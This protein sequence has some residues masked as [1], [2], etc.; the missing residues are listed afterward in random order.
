MNRNTF[1]K[2]LCT[3]SFAGTKLA[4]L[5][6]RDNKPQV[7][8]RDF[9]NLFKNPPAQARPFFRWWWNGNSVTKEG[10]I[11]EINLMHEAGIGGIEINPIAFPKDVDATNHHSLEWLSAEWTDMLKF[12]VEFA[13]KKGMIVDLIIGSGWPFGGKFLES[14]EK[15]QIIRLNEVELK[16]PLRY[17]TT[18]EAL[19][20]PE[21]LRETDAPQKIIFLRLLPNSTDEYHAGTDLLDRIQSDGTIEFD[22]PAGEYLLVAGVWQEGHVQVQHGA[23]GSDGPVLNHYNKA[24]VRKYFDNMA[25]AIEPVMGKLGNSF[26]SFFIDSLELHGA[27]W[28]AD[29]AEEFSNRRGYDIDPYMPVIFDQVNAKGAPVSNKVDIQDKS[30]N[31]DTLQRVRYDYYLT[32]VEL[33]HERFGMVFHNFCQGKNLQSRIQAYGRGWHILDAST[34]PDI[35]EGETW[36]FRTNRTSPDCALSGRNNINLHPPIAN[37]YVTS[38]AQLSNKKIVSCETA[39]NGNAIFRVTPEHLKRIDDLNFLQNLNH[40][41]WSGFNYSPPEA[42]FPGWLQ[43]GPF[44]NEQNPWWKYM[45]HFSDYN[46]RLSSV[47]QNSQPQNDILILPPIVDSWIESGLLR[48]PFPD[49]MKTP[50]Y[51]HQLWIT[52]QQNGY[53]ANYTSENMIQKAEYK[54]GRMHIAGRSYRSLI[55]CSIRTVSPRAAKKIRQLADLGMRIL[56]IGT[57]PVRSPGL[58]NAEQNDLEVKDC[59]DITPTS[60]FIHVD[61]PPAHGLAEW[62]RGI[63][64]RMSLA[65]YIKF[66]NFD[67]DRRFVHYK[68]GDRDIYFFAN[69][70]LSRPVRFDAEFPETGKTPYEWDPETGNRKIYPWNHSRNRLSLHLLPVESKLLV[71]ENVQNVK[72][73][74]TTYQFDKIQEKTINPTWHLRF[75]PFRG[76]PFKKS[77]NELTDF[78]QSPEL[79]T[80]SGR[81]IYEAKFSIDEIG[82]EFLDIGFVNGVT[83][84]SLNNQNL[85]VAWWGRHRFALNSSL[86]IG[87][88]RLEIKLAT[89]MFNY[90][91]TLRSFYIW[92]QTGW[93]R[94]WMD[95]KKPD[96]SGIVGPVRLV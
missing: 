37:K 5:P 82:Y 67:N 95:G 89:T 56:I 93:R 59:F 15:S 55:L 23:K 78:A 18:S 21:K 22:V 38:A 6:V 24:A 42:G 68:N 28:C 71:F 51:V 17:R 54:D 1:L 35:P 53:G 81:V 83:E 49:G 2:I 57:P 39:T 44:F 12:A 94:Q 27:N 52:L 72:T 19:H 41:I 87:E 74:K 84:A 4:C 8:D 62:T 20:L 75:I 29:F 96:S 47:F 92:H 16:G 77:L 46:A 70:N 86:Q 26:R 43:Y 88:N 79:E 80:F 90:A 30:R 85:G 11:R 58:L 69:T 45:K 32:Q 50:E 63:M 66:S 34:I 10:I 40:T 91:R 25:D 73:P 31:S 13:S 9:Y 36:I 64:G 76:Q 33:F 60:R 48:H 14:G 61:E 7:S 3:C 65:P